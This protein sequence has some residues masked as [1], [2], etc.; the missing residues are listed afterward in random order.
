LE[1]GDLLIELDAARK[2]EP[3]AAQ[4]EH[5]VAEVVNLVELDVVLLGE[6]RQVELSSALERLP[7]PFELNPVCRS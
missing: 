3:D 7:E 6:L 1:D 2:P 4:A 5:L